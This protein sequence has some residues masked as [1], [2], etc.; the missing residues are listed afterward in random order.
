[1]KRK[2]VRLA[3]LPLVALVLTSSLVFATNYYVDPSSS[4]STANG[5]LSTPWKTIAQV[6]T[7]S[8]VLLPGDTVF[9]K[10]GQKY[11]GQLNLSKSGSAGKP[12]VYTAYG[13]GSI[14]VFDNSISDIINIY[15]KQYIVIDGFK[16]TDSS[17]DPNNHSIQAK[18]GYGIIISN[19]PN[20]TVQNCEF[21]LVGVGIEVSGSSDYTA[22][23]NNYFYNLRMV[24][25]TVGG[26]DD[27]GANPMVIGSSNNTIEK[28][29]FEECW[30]TSYDYGYDG[31]AVEFYGTTMN[32]NRVINNT[33]INCN[34]FIEIGSGTNGQA[35]NNVI[36]YNKI[37]NCGILGVYQNG[38]TFTVSVNNLQYYNNTVVETVKQY[39]QPSVLFWMAGTGTQ[40]MV[41]VKNNIFWL[42]S[43][44]NVASSKFNSGQMV[45]SNNIFRMTSG[46]PAITLNSTELLSS[47]ANLFESV[48]GAPSTWNLQL[49]SSSVAIDFG[50]PVGF[51]K[52]MESNP[53][54]GNPDAGALERAQQISQPIPSPLVITA[55]TGKIN[56]F[57]GSTEVNIK[58]EGGTAPYSGTGIFK[59]GAGT[60]EYTV[61]DAAGKTAKTTVTVAQPLQL[62]L[63]LSAANITSNGGTTSITAN[64]SGGTAAYTYNLNNGSYQ[65]SGTF[66]N[67]YAGTYAVGV[68]DMNGC[69]AGSNITVTEPSTSTSPITVTG[70]NI[71]IY[72]NPTSTE[73]TV[74]FYR[75]HQKKRVQLTVTNSMGNQVYNV[76]GYTDRNYYFGRSF[77]AGTYFLRSNISGYV[78]TFTLIKL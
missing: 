60:H 5:S 8:G 21:S 74:S 56:C 63:S 15:N 30:A 9:F 20:C 59:V 12:I 49:N 10:R 24:R 66:S 6:N 51:N 67:I 46:T 75:Y 14:P 33:A 26:D 62:Q 2:F 76:R 48:S 35:L 64:A 29:R 71:K 42:S 32:N 70:R 72:P 1:M 78:Q 54:N 44:V 34:G 28:N 69:I 68:K 19:S 7:G 52:D 25:N 50:T 4:A 43:G 17:M 65:V 73:F 39:A 22:I 55:T 36:A 45:H 13:T 16:I 47:S 61:T 41:V 40:G 18:V 3:L 31:G 37:I 38:S 53:I 27:Y 57:G 58:A 23:R 77:P 11:S